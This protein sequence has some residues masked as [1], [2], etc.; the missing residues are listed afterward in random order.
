MDIHTKLQKNIMRN[1]FLLSLKCL[2]VCAL[3]TLCCAC[4]EDARITAAYDLI[5]RVT[6]GYGEQFKLE[7]IEPEDGQ[8]VYEIDA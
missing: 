8:D 7:L 4:R 3:A 6:P 2:V 5:E 1:Y